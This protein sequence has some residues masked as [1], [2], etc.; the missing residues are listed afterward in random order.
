[1]KVAIIGTGNMG[2]AIARGLA[3]GSVVKA[4]DITCSN[5]SMEK[6]EALLREN[7]DF[8]V[9]QSNTEAVKSADIVMLAV[10]PWLMEG[11]INEIKYQL[12]YEKQVV[13]SVA[14]G[15][16]FEQLNRFL[17]RDR[18]DETAV[19]PSLFRVVPNTAIEERCSM[20][21]I[22]ACNALPEQEQLMVSLFN[23]L[24]RSLLVSENLIAAGTALASCG[25]AFALRYIR[26]A[27]EGGI[28]MG[29]YPEQAKELVAQTVK[30]AA[31]LLLAHPGSHPE[32]EIDKVTTPGG[33]TIKGLN[34]MEACGFTTAVI[35]GLKV[36][37]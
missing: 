5:R 12:D 4:S 11:V 1:M 28:E 3:K 26:A 19:I 21:V 29:F 35:E 22:S 23:D 20:T 31:E 32:A 7:K 14:A 27:M 33:I 9:T 30:G 10:K 25:T 17:Q 37:K 36:S 2:G 6:L 34:K 15:I 8:R 16:T 18:M 13:V 24:G